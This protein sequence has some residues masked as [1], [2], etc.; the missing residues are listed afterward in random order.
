[1][2][3]VQILKP[4][5][6]RRIFRRQMVFLAVLIAA[7]ATSNVFTAIADRARGGGLR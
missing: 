5:T 2:D 3:T 6:A 7:S 1:M 4:A